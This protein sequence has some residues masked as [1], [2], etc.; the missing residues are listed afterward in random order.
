M[1]GWVK[2]FST[3]NSIQAEM[4]VFELQTIGIQAVHINKKDSSYPVF[5]LS[6]VFVPVDAQTQAEEFLENVDLD[7]SH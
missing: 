3:K 2:I 4:L 7:T 6:D 5:G 1:E